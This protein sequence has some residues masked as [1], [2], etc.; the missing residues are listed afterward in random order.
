MTERGIGHRL[1]QNRVLDPIEFEREEQQMNRC[2]GEP[3]LNV[4]IK[5]GAGGI[6]RIAG[7]NEPGKGASRPIRSSIAS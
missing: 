7:M 4:A 6:D 1:F 3:L 5:F 2:C